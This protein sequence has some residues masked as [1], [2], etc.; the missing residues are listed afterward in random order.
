MVNQNV[1]SGKWHIHSVRPK[2]Q[3]IYW[4]VIYRFFKLIY[5]ENTKI[6]RNFFVCSRCGLVTKLDLSKNGNKQ[7]RRHRC[8]VEFLETEQDDDKDDNND[9]DDDTQVYLPLVDDGDDNNE[10]EKKPVKT[11]PAKIRRSKP[12]L[13]DLTDG[14]PARPSKV[15][16]KVK[17]PK[18][19]KPV[20]SPGQYV[21]SPSRLRSKVAGPVTNTRILRSSKSK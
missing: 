20:V 21:R 17:V 18:V 13:S 6:V 11:T 19:P 4:S 1:Q 9:D 2:D 8:Y 3:A 5:D 10:V 16:K 12:A 7:L 14:L 15:E